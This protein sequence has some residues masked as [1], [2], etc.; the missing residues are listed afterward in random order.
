MNKKTNR[1]QIQLGETTAVVIIVIIIL[2][3]GI[4]FWS[5]VSASNIKDVQSQSQELSVIEIA[6]IVP[7]LPELKCS[8]SGVSKVKCLDWYKIRAMGDAMSE[9]SGGSDTDGRLMYEFYN[10]YFQNKKITI[11]P[12]YPEDDIGSNS[13]TGKI[14]NVT[15]YDSKAVNKTVT[16]LIYIPVSIKDYARKNTYYGLIVVEGY[17]NELT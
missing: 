7:E 12:L 13:D 16:K 6:N 9:N 1:G 5:K 11:V 3:I 8:E 10:N 14:W 4:V 17:Y 2:V 15:I